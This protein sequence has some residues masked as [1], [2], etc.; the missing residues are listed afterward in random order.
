MFSWFELGFFVGKFKE[1]NFLS[2]KISREMRFFH[3]H[4]KPNKNLKL[5][6]LIF[7]FKIS[8][9]TPR[10]L[11]EKLLQD[12]EEIIIWTT[13]QEMKKVVKILI[14]DRIYGKLCNQQKQSREAEK[15]EISDENYRNEWRKLSSSSPYSAP[16]TIFSL[17][18]RKAKRKT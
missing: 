10:E 8:R 17:A 2:W 7:N 14:S 16:H 6:F 1:F 15:R 13:D 12:D 9:F 4:A 18:Q 3:L 5:L 11:A